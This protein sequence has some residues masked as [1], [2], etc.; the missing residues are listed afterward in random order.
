[1]RAP[2]EKIQAEYE[3]GEITSPELA[4]KW[5]IKAGTIRKRAA[6]EK[7]NTPNRVKKALEDM[8]TMVQGS[9]GFRA[10]LARLS[11]SESA[12]S[13]CHS[14]SHAATM[15]TEPSVYQALVAELAMKAVRN[16]LIKVKTPTSW[17]DIAKADTLARRA[18]GLDSKGGGGSTTMIRVTQPN[19]A[20][21]DVATLQG[22]EAEE[23]FD[24]DDED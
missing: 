8:A 23:Y 14:L 22:G 24:D 5:R 2:W 10:E 13:E 12:G 20:T 1:M 4:A 21:V 6:R 9:S 19:G 18:L 15:P 17:G 11:Q 7:W 16:G 3:S